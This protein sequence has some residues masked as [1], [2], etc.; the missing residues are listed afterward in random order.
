MAL[1]YEQGSKLE[2]KKKKHICTVKGCDSKA[3]VYRQ[4]TEKERW[5]YI[6]I[7][8]RRQA[9]KERNPAGYC[10]QML[11]QNAKRRKKEF[12]ISFEYFKEFCKKT[13]YLEK[14]GRGATNLTIDRIREEE[15]YVEGNIQVLELGYNLRKRFVKYW[16][17]QEELFSA[18]SNESLAQKHLDELEKKISHK[19]R[20]KPEEEAPF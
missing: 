17:E 18:I 6:C 15:G 7:R 10:Y 20:K 2:S 1:R 5:F 9:D 4:G 3:Y 8:H 16:M 19:K 13:G 11:K 12:A 14:K